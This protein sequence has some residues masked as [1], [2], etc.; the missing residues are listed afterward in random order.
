MSSGE[1][2]MEILHN[3]QAYASTKCTELEAN[4]QQNVQFSAAGEASR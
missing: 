4:L 1:R 3:I 2:R